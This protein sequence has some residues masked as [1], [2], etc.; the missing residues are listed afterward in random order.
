MSKVVLACK[1]SPERKALES[2]LAQ[3][4]APDELQVTHSGWELLELLNG[5]STDV[6]LMDLDLSDHSGAEVLT[7]L[8]RRPEIRPASVLAFSGITAEKLQ[9]LLANLDI[10]AL[11]LPAPSAAVNRAMLSSADAAIRPL[12][13]S[14]QHFQRLAAEQLF[15]LSFP[16]NAKGYR[17]LIWSLEMIYQEPELLGLLT[18]ALY[19]MLGRH[20]QTTPSAAER[21]IRHAIE[22]A[23]SRGDSAAW[24]QLFPGGFAGKKPTN[25]EFLAAVFEVLKTTLDNQALQQQ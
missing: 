7:E 1:C 4:C 6:L 24:Q 3:T 12:L 13:P 8:Q 19:P 17:Y 11:L 18:K 23:Y 16:A 2:A 22:V 9:A 21:A 5:R 20:F 10:N 14:P 15:S 25:G